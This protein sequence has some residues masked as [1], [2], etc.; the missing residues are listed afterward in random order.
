MLGRIE[1]HQHNARGSAR[2]PFVR[3]TVFGTVRP[4]A[5]REG[6]Q[7]PAPIDLLLRLSGNSVGDGRLDVVAVLGLSPVNGVAAFKVS[8]IDLTFSLASAA[9]VQVSV[10][11]VNVAPTLTFINTLATA[12]Q[13]YNYAAAVSFVLGI[14]IAGASYLFTIVSNRARRRSVS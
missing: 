10:N 12:N 4:C 11:L 7:G 5:S 3:T 9:P 6:G 2:S 13:Q 14:V 1:L 8:A